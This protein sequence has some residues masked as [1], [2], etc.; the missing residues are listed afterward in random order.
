MSEYRLTSGSQKL[1][2]LVS[3]VALVADL[4]TSSTPDTYINL[5]HFHFLKMPHIHKA[6]HV[7]SVPVFMMLRC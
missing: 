5:S 2:S 7:C 4:D 3:L 1:L 6:I